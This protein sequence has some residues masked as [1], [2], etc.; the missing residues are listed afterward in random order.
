MFKTHLGP[1]AAELYFIFL[2]DMCFFMEPPHRWL[3]EEAAL[4]PTSK[5]E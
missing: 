4:Q 3:S 1:T 2:E 5:K